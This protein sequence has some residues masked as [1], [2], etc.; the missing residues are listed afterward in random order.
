MC[1]REEEDRIGSCIGGV[2]VV[3]LLGD[4]EQRRSVSG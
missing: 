3:A 2:Y 4:S 1:P